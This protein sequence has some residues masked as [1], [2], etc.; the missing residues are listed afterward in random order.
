MGST[1]RKEREQEEMRRRI[2]AAAR[3]LFQQG[4]YGQ[5][6]MR[7]VA[8]RIDYTPT[9]IYQHFESK[10]DLLS[11]VVA[12]DFRSLTRGLVE[13]GQVDDP[14]V[15]L[16]RAMGEYID[17]A[18]AHPMHYALTFMTPVL[19]GEAEAGER[20]QEDP[21]GDDPA[22]SDASRK[23]HAFLRVTCEEAIAMER[24]RPEFQ[25]AEEV[26]QM[27]WSAMHGVVSLYMARRDDPWLEW[28]DVRRTALR[29]CATVIRGL[30]R[31]KP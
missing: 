23:V 30:S 28:T 4:G 6:T 26:A 15:R 22:P 31:P 5:T 17:F 27:L 3:E 14:V 11:A 12:E 2:L 21:R 19:D 25:E 18:L 24:F 16:V 9:V 20:G 10:D 13:T 29:A 1:E 7:A 8:E